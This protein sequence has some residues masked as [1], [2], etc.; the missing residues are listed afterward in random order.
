MYVY[1]FNDKRLFDFEG[2][3]L[4]LESKKHVLPL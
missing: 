1:S 4:F 2:E 3:S